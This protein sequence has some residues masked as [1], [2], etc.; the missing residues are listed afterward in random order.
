[1]DNQNNTELYKIQY[2]KQEKQKEKEKL[3]QELID[4]GHTCINILETYPMKLIW[5]QK[6]I[7]NH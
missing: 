2:D 6:E 1:M 3:Y 4:K 7:C 5:C